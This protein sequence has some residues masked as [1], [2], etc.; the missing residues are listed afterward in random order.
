MIKKG[1][2]IYIFNNLEFSLTLLNMCGS[3][4]VTYQ[5]N[6]LS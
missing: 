5:Y 2:I 4:T 3:F 6:L 1:L